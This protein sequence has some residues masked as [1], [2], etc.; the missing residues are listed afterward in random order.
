MTPF[1]YRVYH[2]TIDPLASVTLSLSGPQYEKA[3]INPNDLHCDCVLYT[4]LPTSHQT[5]G[6]I[7]K[8]HKKSTVR[9]GKS[10]H[11]SMISSSVKHLRSYTNSAI[12]ENSVP[13]SPVTPHEWPR[14]EWTSHRIPSHRMSS[15]LSARQA[16]TSP[17]RSSI[18]SH[19]MTSVSWC[20]T[21]F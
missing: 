8:H 14:I 4:K 10:T 19:R 9:F 16:P 5:P 13:I 17:H 2:C 18:S 15:A 12:A 6:M 11:I 21:M 1:Q 7:P 20:F 3:K